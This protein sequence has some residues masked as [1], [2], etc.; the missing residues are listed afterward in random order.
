MQYNIFTMAD[1]IVRKVNRIS[2]KPIKLFLIVLMMFV[3]ASGCEKTDWLDFELNKSYYFAGPTKVKGW[4]NNIHIILKSLSEGDFGYH[5]DT[6]M[7]GTGEMVFSFNKSAVE[8]RLFSIDSIELDP[9]Y[10]LSYKE[11]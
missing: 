8:A 4:C 11:E 3:F 9:E 6:I 1:I 10:A 7:D 2:A 5:S